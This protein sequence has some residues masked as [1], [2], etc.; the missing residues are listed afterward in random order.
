MPGS[1]EERKLARDDLRE[2]PLH[3]NTHTFCRVDWKW[4]GRKSDLSNSTQNYLNKICQPTLAWICKDSSKQYADEATA[5]S[6]KQD[7]WENASIRISSRDFPDAFNQSMYLS[8]DEVKFNTAWKAY[9]EDQG[10]YYFTA[11]DFRSMLVD[12]QSPNEGECI[13]K[14]IDQMFLKAHIG[15]AGQIGYDEYLVMSYG[16]SFLPNDIEFNSAWKKYF[17]DQGGYITVVDFRRMLLDQNDSLEPKEKYTDESI[18]E[19]FNNAGLE[20]SSKVG[21]TK[22]LIMSN[23]IFFWPDGMIRHS[24]VI[25]GVSISNKKPNCRQQSLVRHAR[26]VYP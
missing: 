26:A 17:E 10:G 9:F 5:Q 6:V 8:E 2:L 22:F 1:Q 23:D 13:N 3:Y 20:S 4:M 12:N 16:I 21:Y 25:P 18:D 24:L 14:S 7:L 19:M 11:V 15:N